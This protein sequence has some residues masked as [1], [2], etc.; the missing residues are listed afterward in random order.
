MSFVVGPLL[1][2]ST[3][4]LFFGATLPA[5][6][7]Q[8]I[9]VYEIP[10]ERV[11]SGMP[12]GAADP[13]AGVPNAMPALKWAKLPEGWKVN[14]APGAMRAASF[15]VSNGEGNE[16]E[17]AAIPMGG[18]SNIEG[19]LV[20]MWRGQVKLPPLN[21]EEM[22][23]QFSDL[24]V[25]DATGKLFELA[26][27]EPVIG[28]KYKARILVAMLKQPDTT[29]FFK[30]AGEDTL[31]AAQRANFLEFLKGV[32][33]EAPPADALPPGHPPMAG[34]MGAGGMGQGMMGGAMQGGDLVKAG[35]GPHPEWVVPSSWVAVDHSSFLVAK[36]RVTGEGGTQ[37][38][39]NVSSSA[40]TGG[41]L[42]PNVNRWR[43]QLSLGAIDQTALD[44]LVTTLDLPVG[45]AT[46][47]D[48]SGEDAEHDTKSRCVGVMVPV[49][50]STWFYKLAGSE[51]VVAREK[52][53]LLNFV[54][55]V[56]Y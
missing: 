12:S 55:S 43:G 25:G 41:G 45:K 40:G 9:R 8:Q 18:M 3:A 47:V 39:I 5:S 44:K 6:A 46:V 4:G 14:P 24:P 11:S 31:V 16:A 54:R 32:S 36:F 1:V 30:F 17:M 26:S 37:A 49:A 23:K 38:D 51:A 50:G 20:N 21:D 15:I 10:K 35:T 19:Q 34:G 13:H 48:F 33:F 2:V 29:W 27:T 56:K 22:A 28:D 42:L 7:R 53:A 52:E